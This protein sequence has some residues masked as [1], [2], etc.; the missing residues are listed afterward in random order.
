ME[1]A[2]L[3]SSYGL[4]S[5]TFQ[6]RLDPR[7][8]AA[9]PSSFV[10]AECDAHLFQTQFE[11]AVGAPLKMV[12][13]YVLDKLKK[14][15]GRAA[16]I[17]IEPPLDRSDGACETSNGWGVELASKSASQRTYHWPEAVSRWSAPTMGGV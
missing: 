1:S 14:S 7:N 11:D 3:P 13:S 9:R 17:S 4:T 6:V 10:Y 2:P 5:G 16:H 12:R 8:P 15:E